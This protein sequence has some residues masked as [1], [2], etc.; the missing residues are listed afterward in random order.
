MP[1]ILTATP[2][3][4]ELA[5]DWR[6]LAFTAVTTLV[7]TIIVSVIPAVV[8]TR[9]DLQQMMA[10]GSRGVAGGRHRL[11]QALVLAQ[12]ALSVTLVGSATLL[13]RS[14]YNLTIVD[15][16]FDPGGVMTFH[17]AAG[18]SEDRYRVGLLQTQLL[19]ELSDAA[20]RAGRRHDELPAGAGRVAAL[21]GP[22]E[23]PDRSKCR[24]RA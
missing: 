13:L 12:V 6:A 24:W 4:N 16:G 7:A 21:L 15:R 11:Q 18:W 20:A 22:G 2:R 23:R 3:M 1:A 5:L 14:Y 10:A 17:V 8:G 9:R 19:S